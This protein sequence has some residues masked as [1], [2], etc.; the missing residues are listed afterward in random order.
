MRPILLVALYQ[1]SLAF[2]PTLEYIL[3]KA[4]CG[5]VKQ[6]Y[7]DEECCGNEDNAS[8]ARLIFRNGQVHPGIPWCDNGKNDG[9]HIFGSVLVSGVFGTNPLLGGKANEGFDVLFESPVLKSL[10]DAYYKTINGSV[11]F[12]SLE[13]AAFEQIPAVF[14]MLSGEVD[15]EDDE[16]GNPFAKFACDYI[17]PKVLANCSEKAAAKAEAEYLLTG[18]FQGILG[19][20]LTG[21]RNQVEANPQCFPS[22]P[23]SHI[24]QWPT[25]NKTSGN[26][27]DK[28]SPGVP[29]GPVEHVTQC[30]TLDALSVDQ[31][32]KLE[33]L[34][35]HDNGN[36]RKFTK[37]ASFEVGSTFKYDDDKCA[38]PDYGKTYKS[39]NS[40]AMNATHKCFYTTAYQ[41]DKLVDRHG[42]DLTYKLLRGTRNSLLPFVELAQLLKRLLKY[43]GPPGEEEYGVECLLEDPNQGPN[44][45]NLLKGAQL[46][47]ETLIQGVDALS[48]GKFNFNYNSALT[49]DGPVPQTEEEMYMK[50][51]F[52]TLP[53]KASNVMVQSNTPLL[54]LVPV[55]SGGYVSVE[56]V[57]TYGHNQSL[58][59]EYLG[60]LQA[61]TTL[62]ELP[63]CFGQTFDG[64]LFDKR[65]VSEK[66]A[67]EVLGNIP[68]AEDLA[69]LAD[70]TALKTTDYWV[71][72]FY[73]ILELASVFLNLDNLRTQAD[74]QAY[75]E[76]WGEGMD[77]KL[78]DTV[79]L[80]YLA[81]TQ[82]C[83]INR[84]DFPLSLAKDAEVDVACNET[85]AEIA[86][87]TEHD[88][89]IE[90]V[91]WITS[92][93]HTVLR[94][95]PSRTI[96]EQVVGPEYAAMISEQLVNIIGP[97]TPYV[98]V[99]GANVANGLKWVSDSERDSLVSFLN[100]K[101]RPSIVNI[102]N[103]ECGAPNTTST[104]C[105]SGACLVA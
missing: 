2:V 6:S 99:V 31:L 91:N 12:D 5:L 20:N 40:Y 57:C 65:H 27:S 11:S 51:T 69:V 103:S 83:L 88:Q 72:N 66:Y 16:Q 62:P 17:D 89:P 100:N 24:A 81:N 85:S 94:D 90:T 75:W 55:L 54:D 80:K 45:K 29:E 41:W 48:S 19:Y 95:G 43:F 15:E 50:Q 73:V 96:L 37:F 39:L 53:G 21:L 13:A 98:V 64:E 9:L 23:L 59:S 26:F 97:N 92:F 46:F 14:K 60:A 7:I 1:S 76:S 18:V 82:L 71:Y 58:F 104:N 49:V 74:V 38:V 87:E 47:I 70:F 52:K 67:G 10:V 63:A 78:S 56:M 35:E 42:S 105:D 22:D 33:H 68:G 79:W 4:E 93:V 77:K 32:N 102:I 84:G 34:V 44:D 28:C 101:L 25:Y 3:P 8:T 30:L 36:D 86:E 61:N